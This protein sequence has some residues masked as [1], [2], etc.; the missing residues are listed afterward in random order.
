MMSSIYHEGARALQDQFDTRRL[1]NRL[2][3]VQA[4]TAFTA[5]DRDF[6]QQ[7]AMFF[8]A[9]ADALGRPECS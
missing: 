4:H 3:L 2:E 8:L 1:A 9:T 5:D 6:I 7:C